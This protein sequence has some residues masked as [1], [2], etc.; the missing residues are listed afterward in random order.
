M[1]RLART[2]GTILP[3][4]LLGL[5][6]VACGDT[7]LRP[8]AVGPDAQLTIVIDSTR[9]QGPIGE[10]IRTGIGQ[11]IPTLP[12]PE[13]SFELQQVSLSNQRDFDR[14]KNLKNVVFV[15]PL[16][17]TTNE[18]R[19]IKSLLSEE[20]QQ[21]ILDGG[22]AVV[23]RNDVWRRRQQIFYVAAATPEAL[24]QTIETDAPRIRNRFNETLRDRL[25]RDMFERGRQPEIEAQMM[26]RH[27]F[28]VNA[29]HDYYVATDTTDLIWLRR[30]LPE[31]WRSLFVYYQEN[32]DPSELTPEWVYATRDSLTRRYVQGSLGDWIEIDRRRPLKTEEIN[33]LD[34]FAYETRGLWHMV[35]IEEGVKVP[36][37]MGGPFLTYA[38]YDQPS[39]RLYLIDGMVFAPSFKKREFL[40]QM[41]V[42]A[43]T[44]RTRQEAEA[45]QQVATR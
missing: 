22:D 31:T 35:G 16:S 26:E 34:R 43:H 20:A 38:F 37:G 32:A 36:Y 45:A 14:V 17:D 15:A 5:L 23:P 30:V 19:F 25:Y 10:A 24:L 42:I 8:E 29:Q 13:P 40:R 39:G 9:W 18:A 2:L 11:L 21:A 1:H 4:L 41:E 28:A 7:D 27:A 3:A 12:N 33:F 44:F 6:F